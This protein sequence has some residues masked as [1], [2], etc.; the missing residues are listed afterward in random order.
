MKLAKTPAKLASAILMLPLLSGCAPTASAADKAE[1][2]FAKWW[3]KFQLAVVRRDVKTID[4]GVEYPMEW[5]ASA[6]VRAVRSESDLAANFGLFFTD[7]IAKNIAAG[8]PAKLPTGNYV[9][10]W[11]SGGKEYSLTLRYYNGEYVL[12]GLSEGPP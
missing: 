7:D 6:G 8:K 1:P 12:D 4:K 2:G 9:L 11:K 5:E 10:V 3:Q